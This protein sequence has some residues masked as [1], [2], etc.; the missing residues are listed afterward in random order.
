MGWW[1][2]WRGGSGGWESTRDR[3]DIC[4][5]VGSSVPDLQTTYTIFHEQSNRP[6]ISIIRLI[7]RRTY[8]YGPLLQ[9]VEDLLSEEDSARVEEQQH[10]Q[11]KTP[12]P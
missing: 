2:G 12:N 1:R 10:P 8:R 6:E 4:P 5:A 9:F 3:F 7:E 11:R